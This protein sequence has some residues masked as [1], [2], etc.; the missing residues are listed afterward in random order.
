MTRRY[1]AA[2]ML[3]SDGCWSYYATYLLGRRNEEGDF[4]TREEAQQEADRL[5]HQPGHRSIP[6]DDG[7]RCGFCG[8]H[9]PCL[10]TD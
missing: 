10:R 5:N 6:K 2:R 4:P 7:S 9:R 3:L 8:G 1:C